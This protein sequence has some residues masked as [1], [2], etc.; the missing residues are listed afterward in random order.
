MGHDV[1][2]LRH[3]TSRLII[4]NTAILAH[5]KPALLRYMAGFV[6]TLDW[7]YSDPTAIKAYA[8]WSGLPEAIARRAPE[9]LTKDNLDPRRISG[10]DAIM[11]DAVTFKY[12]AAPLSDAEL[13]EVIQIPLQ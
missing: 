1:P 3:M 4:A 11:A 7:L 10:L 9:F 6:E 5:K 12:L 13:N 8:R 2:A